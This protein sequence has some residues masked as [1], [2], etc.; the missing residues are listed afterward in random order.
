VIVK[1]ETLIAWHRNG[2]KLFWK[3]KSRTGRPRIPAE[4]RQ[5]IAEMVRDNP[6]WG[7]ARI[8]DELVLKLGIKVSPRHGTSLLAEPDVAYS[9]MAGVAILAHIYPQSCPSGRRL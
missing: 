7:P 8:A 6:T 3:R 1:P 9:R 2:F 5:L 4:L